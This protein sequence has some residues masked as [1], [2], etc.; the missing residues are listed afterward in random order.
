MTKRGVVFRH[1][2]CDNIRFGIDNQQVTLLVLLDFLNAF[3]T[4][5]ID[6]LLA[7]LKSIYFYSTA[8]ERFSS[9]GRGRRQRVILDSRQSSLSLY[10]LV[11]G[12]PQGGM[13]SPLLFSAFSA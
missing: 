2:V 3:N 4:V 10:G 1:I 13:L 7:I 8:T 6:I 11:A 5:D 12:V 9:Y